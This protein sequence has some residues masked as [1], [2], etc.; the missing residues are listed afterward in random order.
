MAAEIEEVVVRPHL[1]NAQDLG[2]DPRQQLLD[3]GARCAPAPLA[4]FSRGAPARR[5]G[6]GAESGEGLPVDLAVG[7]ERQAFQGDEV[8]GDHVVGQPQA[9]LVAQAL[10]EGGPGGG[11]ARHDI[12]DQP[13]VAGRIRRH[14]DRR[15]DDPR[16]TGER[17]LDLLQLDPE[18]AHLDLVV[19]PP[20]EVD[21]AVRQV[22][23]EV[24]RAVE[25][26]SRRRANGSGTNFSAVSSGRPR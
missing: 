10:D 1:G 6:G 23:R 15:L 16:L 11:L 13:P 4:P 17:R 25:P 19:D 8:G 5:L 12:G 2:P 3:R 7:G 24:A 18:A 9:Q 26:R 22:P 20:Q 14:E 21:L